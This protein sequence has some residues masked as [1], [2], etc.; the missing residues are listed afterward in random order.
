MAP[1]RSGG[2]A[3]RGGSLPVPSD[4]SA[5]FDP[6]SG[7]TRS[8]RAGDPER[9][10]RLRPSFR[11]PPRLA[12]ALGLLDWRPHE[13]PPLGPGAVVVPHIRVAEEVLQHEPGVRR[14]LADPAVG[15]DLLVR[16]HALRLVKG[17][18]LLRRLEGPVL[19]HG[20][21]PR[22]VL[23]ARDVP[24]ALR[25]FRRI[26]RRGQDL[27]A[28]FLWRSHVDQDFARLPVR[29]SD[30]GQVDSE[31]LV[32]FL[33][34]EGGLGERRDVL[35][36]GQVLLDPLPAT[37]VQED[38][39]VHAVILEDPEGEGREPV[40]EVPIEDDLVVIGDPNASKER[41]EP[42]LRDDVPG[43]G[44][45]DVLAP[46]DQ[47]GTGDVSQVVVRRGIVVHLDD[48]DVLIPKGAFH[49]A[50]VNQHFRMRVCGH[51]MFLKRSEVIRRYISC[52][53]VYSD[54]HFREDVGTPIGIRLDTLA[55]S[56]GLSVRVYY[57][58]RR[59]PSR[60]GA[61]A[62]APRRGGGTDAR[63][64]RR[65]DGHWCART[66]DR[67]VYGSLRARGR[68]RPGL[69]AA[70]PGF[71]ARGQGVGG[72][73]LHLC[74]VRYAVVPRGH[75]RLLNPRLRVRLRIRGL[76]NPGGRDD[77]AAR[78]H[79]VRSPP[80]YH[81]IELGRLRGGGRPRLIR[82]GLRPPRPRPLWSRRPRW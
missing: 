58:T 64:S 35:R 21:P 56:G 55:R 49:E 43:H 78:F 31:S 81:R 2:A 38:D 45:V 74:A 9:G 71:P 69:L 62:V 25:M 30:V 18:Q 65:F 3:P 70:L 57:P 37:A 13:I 44:I 54:A 28:E 46:V 41:L 50:R 59:W 60:R 33:R 66:F 34:R 20:L 73:R 12:S 77:R 32:R 27:P 76:P 51:A 17:P 1:G 6:C 79:L 80:G 8:G 52:G 5:G 7:R 14:P 11:P 26:F 68:F 67:F 39:V 61:R 29:L 36:H 23:R 40:V 47:R 15:D 10:P 4:A 16:R 72:L 48:L 75:L 63:P 22:D 53:K 82:H 42:V 19:V 24:A